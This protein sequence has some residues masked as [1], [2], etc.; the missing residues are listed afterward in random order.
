MI[1]KDT[2]TQ[3]INAMLTFHCVI[4]KYWLFAR[5]YIGNQNILDTILFCSNS[6]YCL[7]NAKFALGF[8]KKFLNKYRI[9]KNIFYL[10]QGIILRN[11]DL[12]KKKRKKK[13]KMFVHKY[14]LANWK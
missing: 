10:M 13:Y 7:F 6:E 14:Q 4:L 2:L 9:A 1:L 11:L 8:K 5:K 12:G 3:R